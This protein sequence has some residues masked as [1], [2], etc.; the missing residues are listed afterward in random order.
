ML[1]LEAAGVLSITLGISSEKALL[2]AFP[3]LCGTAKW[4]GNFGAHALCSLFLL[5]NLRPK[6]IG[7]NIFIFCLHGTFI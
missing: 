2:H 3:T 5:Y 7:G 4:R 6:R 1:L